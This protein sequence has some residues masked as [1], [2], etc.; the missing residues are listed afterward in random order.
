VIWRTC[1][2]D[3]PVVVAHHWV[4]DEGVRDHLDPT[5]EAYTRGAINPEPVICRVLGRATR[6]RY[7]LGASGTVGFEGREV[8]ELQLSARFNHLVGM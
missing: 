5:Q 8:F 7:R 3:E 1:R 2:R 6:N 4:V